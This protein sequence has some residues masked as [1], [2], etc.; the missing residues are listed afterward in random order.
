[1]QPMGGQ[2]NQMASGNCGHVYCYDCLVSASRTQVGSASQGPNGGGLCSCSPHAETFMH[3]L[4]RCRR[5]A[6]PA[7][8]RCSSAKSRSCSSGDT[9]C[10][11][12][13]HSPA[14]DPDFRH[15]LTTALQSSFVHF[16]LSNVSGTL[17]VPAAAVPLPRPA[18]YGRP[19]RAPPLRPSVADLFRHT[20]CALVSA[21]L[22][23]GLHHL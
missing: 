19:L 2:G 10:P 18:V 16:A 20:C 8:S 5:N 13:G 14:S 17:A 1:M 21:C 15:S 6:Q 4:A 3:L 7:E 22:L 23:S 11:A 12:V 9:A